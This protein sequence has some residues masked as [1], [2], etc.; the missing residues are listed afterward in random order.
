MD[1]EKVEQF[2]SVTSCENREL[3][4]QYLEISDNDVTRA[5]SLFLE[6]GWNTLTNETNAGH[7]STSESIVSINDGSRDVG[8]D[9]ET[10]NPLGLAHES[11]NPLGLAQE[12]DEQMARRL[13]QEWSSQRASNNSSAEQVRAPMARTRGVLA[14]P[15]M[16]GGNF[17]SPVSSMASSQTTASRRHIRSVFDPD[18][19]DPGVWATD[20]VEERISQ[21]T[22]ASNDRTRK[23]ARLFAPPWDIMTHGTFEQSR[24]LAEREFKWLMVNLQDSSNFACQQL[25]RDIWSS[26]SLKEIIKENFIFLQ[27]KTGSP[28]GQRYEQFY[29]PS[30]FPHVSIIDPRTG[31]QVATYS[32]ASLS[33]AADFVMELYNFLD[34]FSL[35]PGHKNPTPAITRQRHPD[36]MTEEQQIEAA[37]MASFGDHQGIKGKGKQNETQ[38]DL[39]D[40]DESSEEIDDN[41]IENIVNR[42][43]P[44][45]R[46]EPTDIQN[47]TRIQIRLSDGTR[48]VRRFSL[49]DPVRYIFEYV[50]SELSETK[51]KPFDLYFNRKRLTD[52]LGDTIESAQLK[53]ASIQFEWL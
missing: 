28:E 26:E 30:S 21:S 49:T 47:T 41:D 13:D 22:G 16:R 25:N 40:L 36:H 15:L 19:D 46:D 34:K 12:T 20:D 37:V 31:E 42:I 7:M 4:Q 39:V 50:K 33:S 32:Q 14:E 44:I 6:T 2:M 27:Y 1:D 51:D 29:Q 48:K 17:P 35:D 3:A 10:D 23:L 38:Q 18:M 8:L 45:A 5:V 9:Q 53:N 11:N 43:A 24:E 52:V